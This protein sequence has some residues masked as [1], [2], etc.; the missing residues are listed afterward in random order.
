M[1]LTQSYPELNKKV[2]LNVDDDAMNQLVIEKILEVVGAQTVCVKNGAA[3]VRKM[4]EGF[5]PDAILMDIQMP[6]MGGI[7]A[8]MIIRKWIDI[9]VPIIINT[10]GIADSDREKLNSMGIFDFLEKPY[11]QA[12]IFG[13]LMKN[14]AVVHE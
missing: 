12:D 2:I 13:K 9:N 10:G 14:V 3:A 11:N 5:K 6:V 8:C 1:N 7:E 4:M